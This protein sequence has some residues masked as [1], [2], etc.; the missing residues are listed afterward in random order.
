MKRAMNGGQMKKIVEGKVR[1]RRCGVDREGA[2]GHGR[3]EDEG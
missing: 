1:C 2:D 3:R